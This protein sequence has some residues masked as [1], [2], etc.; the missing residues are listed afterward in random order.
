MR[1]PIHKRL[2]R[3]ESW[4][5]ITFMACLCER[6]APNFQLFC[7]LTD[8]EQDAKIYQN[9]LNLVWEFLTVK[10]ARINFDNQLEKLEAIIP[11][12]E[13]YDF[14]A[15]LPAQ[16]ACEGLA[17]LLHALIAGS[18]LE[19]SIE[20][21]QLSIKTLIELLEI[22]QQKEFTESELKELP[23][24]EQEFD[25]QWQIFRALKDS[26]ERDVALILDLKKELRESGISN[27][28]IENKR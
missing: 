28:G 26:E 14:Y 27:I 1:N 23:E 15:V 19:R 16:D 3:L 25:V 9:I 8:K 22:E 13:D 12:S 4:Q 21:S 5:H 18:T 6:M 10:D 17:E 24:I 2:E 11:T 7:E 20:L